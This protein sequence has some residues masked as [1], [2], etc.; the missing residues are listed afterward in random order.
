V[1][2]HESPVIDSCVVVA[3]DGQDVPT[4]YCYADML[5]KSGETQGVKIR[6]WKET[7][8]ERYCQASQ[9]LKLR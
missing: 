9:L 5:K 7:I 8:W 2:V 4:P 6:K 3:E 1:E